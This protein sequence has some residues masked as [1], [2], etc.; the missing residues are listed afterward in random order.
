MKENPF[1][2]IWD[3]PIY[4]NSYEFEVPEYPLLVDAELTNKCNMTCLFCDRQLMKRKQGFMDETL[5]R[6]IIDDIAENSPFVKA[7]KF[8]RWGEPALHPK[9]YEFLHM[10]KDLGLITHVTSN[11][12]LLDPKKCSVI[13]SLNISMQG[14]TPEEYSKMRD[15]EHYYKLVNNIIAIL[16]EKD[17][18]FVNLSVT[19]LDESEE[20]IEE[21]KKRWWFV[22]GIG[23][24]Q[25]SFVR[26]NNEELLERQS[27]QGR[28]EPCDNVRTRL[29][30]DWDGHV[31]PCCADFDRYLT[32]GNI[33]ENS[34]KELWNNERITKLREKFLS[35]EWKDIP[36]CKTCSHR[37]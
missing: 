15:T 33:K 16:R 25:T 22:D 29:S 20:E 27:W 23:M 26:V 6:K 21:F 1:R 5:F 17:R 13:D 2:A 11:G 8:S 10:A 7:I 3:H 32:I 4:N 34:I 28:A 14:L 30:I 9:F 19:V 36:F 24:G 31:T 35:Q 12:L 18:P 37:W